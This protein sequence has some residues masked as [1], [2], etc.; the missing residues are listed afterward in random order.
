[1]PRESSIDLSSMILP[2]VMKVANGEELSTGMMTKDGRFVYRG[3]STA[4]VRG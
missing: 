2:H 3:R 4:G 1:M